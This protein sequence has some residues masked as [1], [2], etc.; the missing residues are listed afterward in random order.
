MP[1]MDAHSTDARGLPKVENT[2]PTVETVRIGK[3]P[4]KKIIE[5][6]DED[7]PIRKRSTIARSVE[8][9]R[10][11]VPSTGAG[12]STD[13]DLDRD[14]PAK[15]S[16]GSRSKGK[17]QGALSAGDIDVR[18]ARPTAAGERSLIRAL[19]LKIGKIVIDP[20]HGGH[21]TGTIGPDGLLE[22][23]LVVDVGRRLGKLL[24]ARLGAEVIYT[25]KD[26]TFIP[27]ETRTAIANQEQ[28]DLFVSI[29]ANS[30]HDANARGVET[31]YLNFTSSADA[32][33]VAAARKRGVGE[34]RP[35]TRRPGEEDRAQ[36][37]DRRIP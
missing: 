26:D 6:K 29:H 2:K 19:G 16:S 20:G 4:V 17:R 35:R 33:E 14:V 8:D 21:D 12:D 37:K 22:K 10:P 5:A 11:D 1:P 13:S 15:K 24:E 34:V 25:R 23:E 32:L 30:S 3:N 18:E 28:A 27:L 7:G 31:Y 36:G 9:L